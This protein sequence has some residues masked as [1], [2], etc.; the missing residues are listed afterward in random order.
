MCD[1]IDYVTHHAPLFLVYVINPP[2]ISSLTNKR[3][4]FHISH[5]KTQGDKYLN[6]IQHC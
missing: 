5:D 2:D 3:T 6:H 1:R 4:N